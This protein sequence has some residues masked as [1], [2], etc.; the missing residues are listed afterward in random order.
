ML[1]NSAHFL[2]FFPI[3]IAA[4]YLLPQRRRWMLLLPASCYFYM[5]L[6][7]VYILI[8]AFLIAIDYTAGLLIEA[9]EGR[10][11]RMWLVA[12]LVANIGVLA[13][14]KYLDF[15]SWN[16][17]QL[18]SALHWNYSVKALE[19]VLPVGLSFHTFQSMSYTIE[20]YR[21]R[22][23]AERHL[24][25]FALYVLF[26]PQL[27]AGPI[28]RPQNLLHQFRQPD[29]RPG[30][31]RGGL[32]HDFDYTNVVAGLR[33]ILW[34][35]FKKVV[36]A[37]RLALAVNAVYDDPTKFEGWP[38]IIA[39]VFFAFQIYCDFSGYSDIALGAAQVMGIKLMT[40]FNRPYLARSIAEFWRRWHIS[41]STWFRDYLYISL[42][43]NRVPKWHWYGNL[44]VTFLVSGLW[45]GAN[46]T[47]VIWG[48]LHGGYLI[49]SLWTQ[50]I[51]ERI[52]TAVGLTRVPRVRRG[53][54]V[55]ITFGLACFAWIF[56]RAR[57]VGDGLYIAT[58]FFRD[59][60]I[61]TPGELLA[62]VQATL[63]GGVLGRL[64]LGPLPLE[65]W[66]WGL[67]ALLLIGMMVVQIRERREPMFV[68]LAHWPRWQRWAVYYA[69]VLGIVFFGKYR[70][71]EF[72]YF[73]F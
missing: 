28:E 1:F 23:P 14:F 57:S 49:V 60:R 12:S 47:F 11:R 21:R 48:A 10:R 70:N 43:G 30:G 41:L 59:L 39:T 72:I 64:G 63:R 3:V 31:S 40:N 58:H 36:I 65:R 13:V 54:Q 17:A 19:I 42:G 20:V 69:M 66:E 5:A 44:M 4:Y 37:D 45:H 50:E 62:T 25:Y 33:R 34:G 53:L 38:L 56:F 46:W 71:A 29:Y 55:A 68:Q 6:I 22:Q 27:V 15:L 24:G 51:R 18:A 61:T 7:P 35:M 67:T 8:L 26:F 9:A 52:A 73:Q 16:A 32:F 2:V